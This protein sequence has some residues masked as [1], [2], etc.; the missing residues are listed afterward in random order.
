MA[1]LLLAVSPYTLLQSM[2][3]PALPRIQTELET[4]QVTVAWVL[5][6]FLISASV[7][8]PIA[9]RLGDAYGRKRALVTSLVLLAV[10]GLAASLATSIW[11]LVAAR[12]VQGLA[13]GVL[14][15]SFAIVRDEL[16]VE[17]VAS[18][19]GSLSSLMSA[20]FAAGIVVTGPILEHFGYDALFVLPTLMAAVAAVGTALYV[21]ES[22]RLSAQPVR[23]APAV[24][25]SAWLVLLLL[26]VTSAPSWGWTSPR[27]L[28]GLG[29][30]LVVAALWVRIESVID[31]PLIDLRMAASRGIAAPN[32]VAFLI[33][34]AMFGSFAFLPQLIQTPPGAGYGFG[35]SVGEAGHLMLPMSVCSFLSAMTSTRLRARIGARAQ[36]V[37]GCMLTAC[38][39]FAAAFAHQ[40]E[41][42]IALSGALSGVGTG[43]VFAAL[44]NVV[45]DAAPREKTG[46]ATGINANLR[47]IG[48]AIG[49]AVL[50]TTV[51]SHLLPSGLPVEHGYTVGFA[52]LAVTAVLAGVAGFAIPARAR[53]T[54]SPAASSPGGARCGVRATT[55]AT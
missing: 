4:D 1:V 51:T 55:P 37:G 5:T 21:P 7:A 39:L 36:I 29:A 25:L 6:A 53:A 19:I 32:L 41:W 35:A 31:A 27:T 28:L 15:L 34:V 52:G 9:G 38:G 13:G 10:G 45:V 47:T 54:T 24:A 33:G 26:S 16:P 11:L 30:A 20:G 2:T 43:F 23:I 49:T 14:P 46:V 17:R 40:L 12:V 48:G 18:A 8:T 22:V 44:A 42:Q 50:A 3:V